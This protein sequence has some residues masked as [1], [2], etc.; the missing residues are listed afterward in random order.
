MPMTRAP[1]QLLG[2][3]IARPR[4][5]G[6][7]KV[8]LGRALRQALKCKGPPVNFKEWRAMAEDKSESRSRTCLKPM[9]FSD[10]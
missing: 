8:T 10:N 4:L 7:Q 2:G 5:K 6:F 9:P 1:G 3:W